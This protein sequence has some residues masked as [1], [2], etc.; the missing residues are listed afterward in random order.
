[1]N[2]IAAHPIHIVT[3]LVLVLIA[4]FGA[5]ARCVRRVAAMR[6][7]V[8][9][10]FARLLARRV[11]L[12]RAMIYEGDDD[13]TV[14]KRIAR[15]EWIARDPWKALRHLSRQVRGWMRSRLCA[16]VAPQS[17]SPP[18]LACVALADGAGAFARAP[19]T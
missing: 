18:V 11:T 14:E 3:R 1:M 12:G 13:A 8:R 4:L 15:M 2:Q 6:G 10:S 5:S 17:F 9:G 19:D 7:R 16:E